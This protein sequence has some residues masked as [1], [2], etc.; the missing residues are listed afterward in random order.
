MSRQL[1]A[2]TALERAAAQN[3]TL[4]EARYRQGIDP[5]L[6]TLDAQRTLYAARQT[7][8]STRLARAQNLVALYQG[9]AGD[10]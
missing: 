8:A 9:L 6:N 5:Y 2:Q 10:Q 3:F 7:L 1:D 4:S